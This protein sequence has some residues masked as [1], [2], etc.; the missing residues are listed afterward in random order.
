MKAT[1][2]AEDIEALQMGAL[3]LLSKGGTLGDLY[4]Y[5]DKEYEAIY[6]LG[7]GFYSQG[8][9]HDALKAFGFLMLNNHMDRRFTFSF[10]A[11]CQMLERYEEAVRCYAIAALMDASDPTPYYHIGECMICLNMPDDAAQV[12]QAVIDEAGPKH[13]ELKQRA[14]NLR[15]MLLKKGSKS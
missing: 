7:H 13:A 9:Y 4:S 15:A 12:F 1:D 6:V 14:E 8:R 3:D 2:S 5:T 11:A 10:A